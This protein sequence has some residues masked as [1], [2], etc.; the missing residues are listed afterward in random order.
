MGH[1]KKFLEF[2]KITRYIYLG[3]NYCCMVHFDKNL[4]KKH[5]IEADLSLEE[6][7]IDYPKGV[8]YFL[9]LPLKDNS[10]PSQELLAT[11]ANFLS[12]ME[13]FK[14]K[15]YV[16]CQNG[17]KRSPTLVAAFLVSKG[18]GIG[19]SLSFVKKK[20]PSIHV[21][22][23]YLKALKKFEKHIEKYE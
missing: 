16:H 19:K 8:K 13:K 20:R 1:G 14:I 3:N 17:H 18:M 11:G 6:N 23:Q 4:L 10:E 21:S 12:Q 5:K 2:N 7:R 15:T 22:G 9:W